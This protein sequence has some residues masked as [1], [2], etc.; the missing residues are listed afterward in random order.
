MPGT[1]VLDDPMFALVTSL[2]DV[3]VIGDRLTAVCVQATVTSVPARGQ[4]LHLQEAGRED[5]L[6]LSDGAGPLA[7]RSVG[8]DRI[9]NERMGMVQ[10]NVIEHG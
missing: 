3:D 2:D 5:V 1:F 4:T 10:N 7:E 6:V 9:W 8:Q